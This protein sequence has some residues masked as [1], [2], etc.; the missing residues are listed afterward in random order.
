MNVLVHG[1]PFFCDLG[2]VRRYA[3]LH[4][5]RTF[6]PEADCDYTY[7]P[8][9]ETA[10]EAVARIERDWRP[11]MLM[12]WQPE[13]QPPP[14]GVEDVSIRTIA[15]VSDWNMCY[16]VLEKNLARY[17]VTLTDK[18]GV[19]IFQRAGIVAHHV[20]PLYSQ[21]TPIHYPH[22]VE[23]DI[24][25]LF[26]GNLNHAAHYKRAE[27]LERLAKLSDRHR[28][29]ITTH[30]QGEAYGRLMSRARI[31]FNHSIRG[32]LNVRVF[33]TMACGA[34]AILEDT[35]MEVRDWF[36][37]GEDIVLYNGSNFEEVV[38]HYLAHPADAQ[39]IAR[40][41]HERIGLMSG[42]HTMDDVIA[43]AGKLRS[44]GRGFRW[45]TEHERLLHTALMYGR[46]PD[47]HW[48]P[49][50]AGLFGHLLE[51]APHDAEVHAGYV[52]FL[53]GE[54]PQ[55]W[56]RI[57]AH[58]QQA[59]DLAPDSIPFAWNLVQVDAWRSGTK[60][61]SATLL[62]L[63]E[64]RGTQ[65]TGLLLGTQADPFWTRCYATLSDVDE[66][67]V[68]MLHAEILIRSVSNTYDTEEA[69]KRLDRA[70]QLDPLNTSC[71]RRRSE[72]MWRN[73]QKAEAAKLLRNT[74]GIL[75]L[76][77]VA[78]ETLLG[79]L[80]ELNQMDVWQELT[81]ETLRILSAFPES[82]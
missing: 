48:R 73:G 47:S 69:M 11:D 20:R 74:L 42:E 35:N 16:P 4:D 50:S 72:V 19:A 68:D 39:Q 41:G 33:E 10:A 57:R 59:A 5:L 24:D 13:A 53:L 32:E 8:L 1:T 71:A 75:P 54:A 70:G 49:Y 81:A 6:G 65:G 52:H 14:R 77:M 82:V 18:P 9:E 22:D 21:I 37:D 25:V 60:P 12:C 79:W 80:K 78:R 61:D 67:A 26:V 76:D 27:F 62:P 34:M 40:A 38:S 56:E 43:H 29:I 63:L 15:L 2:I 7:T 3:G 44:S 31:V 51:S 23:R 45:F 28:I 17:D 58:A 66:V 55:D 36:T 46:L 30:L 64:K